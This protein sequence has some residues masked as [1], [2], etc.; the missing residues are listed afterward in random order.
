LDFPHRRGNTASPLVAVVESVGS[1]AMATMK[2]SPTDNNP[3]PHRYTEP[4]PADRAHGGTDT[5]TRVRRGLQS[6]PGRPRG[7]PLAVRVL[8]ALIH[9]RTN[10]TTRAPAALF[11]TSQSTNRPHHLPTWCRC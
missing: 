4:D 8:L 2:P 11:H 5:Y 10:L 7:S 3:L 1:A 6:R 9:L